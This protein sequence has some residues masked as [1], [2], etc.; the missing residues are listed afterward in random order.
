MTGI[1]WTDSTWNPVTGCSHVSTAC[2]HCYAESVSHRFGWTSKPWTAEHAAENVVC[3]PNRYDIPLKW[4]KPRRIFV[5]SMGDLFHE[6]VPDRFLDDMFGAMA[7]AV[8][9]RGHLFMVLT[10]RPERMLEYLKT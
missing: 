3:H 9:L 5:C 8:H 7:A 1:S 10:K 4:A 2:D 6:R